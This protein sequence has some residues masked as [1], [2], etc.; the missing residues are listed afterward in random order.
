MRPRNTKLQTELKRRRSLSGPPPFLISTFPR[1]MTMAEI[2]EEVLMQTLEKYGWDK[3]AVAKELG[4]TLKTV[5][6]RVNQYTKRFFAE[7]QS[8]QPDDQPTA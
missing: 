7:P 2:E 3:P 5:Y 4:L 8:E 6:N 1:V